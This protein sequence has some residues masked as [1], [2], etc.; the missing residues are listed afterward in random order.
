MPKL[1]NRTAARVR[2]GSENAG[3]G[4]FEPVPEGMYQLRLR[5]VAVKEVSTS[6]KE[7]KLHGCPMW[8][9]EFEIPEGQEHAGRRFW[10]NRILPADN[11]YQ[12]A[13]FML[14]KFAEPFEAL[15][16]T[17]ED[18]TDTLIGRTC[19]GYIVE[20]IIEKGAKA[21]EMTNS[22]EDLVVDGEITVNNAFAASDDGYD[23][24]ED[25]AF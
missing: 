15:G 8:T 18:D 4:S 7:P 20:R 5:S 23:P 16:G 6:G 13:D 19:R 2:T 10:T 3:D 22:L 24:D 21:G 14:S 9:W 25:P 17:V 11:G 12:H 1:D